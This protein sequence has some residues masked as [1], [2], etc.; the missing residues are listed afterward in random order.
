MKGFFIE[1]TNNLLDPKHRAAMRES[2]WL[3]MWCLD[4]MTSINEEGIGF[5]LGGK[6]IK[7]EEVKAE[8]GISVR[9]YRRWTDQLK[10]SGY[11]NVLRTPYGCVL[12]VNK[13]RKRFGRAVNN[14][15]SRYARS[16]TSLDRSG[17]SNK[18]VSVRQ[19]NKDNTI[20]KNKFFKNGNGNG[21]QIKEI[22]Q[23]KRELV[24]KFAFKR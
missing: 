11:I 8:L 6:P 4:K 23:K 21:E 17:T 14:G 3:F 1:V 9:T 12:T 22:M 13:A 24:E 10:K 15:T 5:V 7:Y 2:V 16:G 19:I 18:T 20:I